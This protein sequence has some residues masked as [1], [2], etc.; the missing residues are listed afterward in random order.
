MQVSIRAALLC[1]GC[2]IPAARKVCGFVGHRALKGCLKCLQFFPT[3]ALILVKKQI[4]V[5]LTKVAGNHFATIF[6]KRLQASTKNAIHVVN[7][8]KL[9]GLM[10][11]STQLF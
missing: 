3:T 7:K 4:I 8:Y 1:V 10:V 5:T 11:L 2:D 9:S 6:T